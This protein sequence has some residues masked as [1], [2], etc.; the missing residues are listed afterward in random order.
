M[1]YMFQYLDMGQFAG[2]V[3]QI[4]AGY[5]PPGFGCSF[6]EMADGKQDA[7]N[8]A[9][10]A[11][12]YLLA[13]HGILANFQKGASILSLRPVEGLVAIDE[14]ET[15]SEVELNCRVCNHPKVEAINTLLIEGKSLRAIED[16]FNVSRSTLSRHKNNCLNLGVIRIHD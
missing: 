4:P 5:L 12:S 9:S 3:N 16:E 2:A 14:T 1:K 15:T 10:E 6:L 13:A 11:Y 7:L 8:K